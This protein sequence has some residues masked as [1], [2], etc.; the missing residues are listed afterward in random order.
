MPNGVRRMF[1]FMSNSMVEDE[2]WNVIGKAFA[3]DIKPEDNIDAVIFV[4][5]RHATV[6]GKLRYP[7]GQIHFFTTKS[8]VPY[9]ERSF[10]AI[11]SFENSNWLEN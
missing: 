9:L 10:S 7:S 1:I 3:K 4:D 2:D 8:R 5:R 11:K 6:G